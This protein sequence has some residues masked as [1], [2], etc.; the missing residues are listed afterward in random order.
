MT[1]LLLVGFGKLARMILALNEEQKS[2]Y[3]YNR[4]AWKVKK[5]ASRDPRIRYGGTDTFMD[6]KEAFLALPPKACIDFL[7]ENRYLFPA[8]CTFYLGATALMAEEVEKEAPGLHVVPAK[9]AGHAQQAVRERNGGLFLMPKAYLAERNELQRW[10]GPAFSVV[11]AEEKNAAAANKIAVEETITMIDALSERLEQ[12]NIPE[13]I[14]KTVLS[15]IP[16]GVIQAHLEE[17]HGR[18][19]EKIWQSLQ[20]KKGEQ[21]NESR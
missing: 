2:F 4:T 13:R 18:F 12:E 8:D 14:Q 10:L 15:Q 1:A 16:A 19:A 5:A 9:F 17:T 3:I 21:E 7:K 11:E 20:H 6:H